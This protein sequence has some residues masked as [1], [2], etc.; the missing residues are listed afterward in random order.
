MV[1]LSEALATNLD[2]LTDF[3]GRPVI[4]AAIEIPGAAGGLRE[5]M[6][7]EP[8]E[9]HHGDEVTLVIRCTV[10]KVR[11]D[12]IKDTDALARVHVFVAE[13]ATFI[14]GALVTEA[15]AEHRDLDVDGCEECAAEAEALEDEK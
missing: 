4:R 5:A 13:E 14:D 2:A 8:A 6:K 7:F 12:P 15:L 11:F 9:F 10:G 3:E 1:E